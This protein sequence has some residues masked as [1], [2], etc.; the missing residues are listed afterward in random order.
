MRELGYQ[1]NALARSLRRK[2]THIIGVIVPDSAN[3]FFAEVTRALEVALFKQQYAVILGNSDGDLERERLYTNTLVEKQV[4]GIVFVAVGQTGQEHA[5]LIQKMQ[6]PLVLVDRDV[7][8][9]AVD[10]VL[11]DNAQG[12]RLATE[13]LLALGHRRIGCITGPSDL[14]PSADRVTGYRNALASAQIPIDETII[15]KGDFQFQSGFD[16]ARQL[17]TLPQ[18]PTAIFACND[19]S[20]V[21]AVSAAVALGLR[22]P[23]DVSVVGFDDVP[24]A[25]FAN[26]P[27][28][29]IHQPSHEMGAL[30]AEILLGRLQNRELPPRRKLLETRLVVRQSTAPPNR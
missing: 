24:L 30:A 12:G 19:L 6:M 29:T 17:L 8:R 20:A 11:A 27:L 5:L 7:P 4:D 22:V 2:K 25:S 9:L 14:T 13:H 10:S 23:Q 26:P 16:A 1:P 21:G 28:T 15:R 18:P 3:P